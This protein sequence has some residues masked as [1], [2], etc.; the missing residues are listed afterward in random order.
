MTITTAS[1]LRNWV[2]TATSGWYERTD[3]DLTIMT[4]KIRIM[5]HP[6]WGEDWTEFFETLPENLAVLTL[7]HYFKITTTAESAAGGAG[8]GYES[9]YGNGPRYFWDYEEAVGRCR[10]LNN[11]EPGDYLNGT[12]SIHERFMGDDDGDDYA[13]RQLGL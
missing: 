1:D 12:Y 11:D 5:S 6:A 3:A 7:P 8:L 4:E 2:D 13:K 9:L 10:D